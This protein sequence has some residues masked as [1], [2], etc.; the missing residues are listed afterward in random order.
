MSSYSNNSSNPDSFDSPPHQTPSSTPVA[1]E[2]FTIA[3]ELS[4]RNRFPGDKNK[5][6]FDAILEKLFRH[7][8]G[9][10]GGDFFKMILAFLDMRRVSDLYICFPIRSTKT[11]FPQI[12]TGETLKMMQNVAMITHRDRTASYDTPA[13]GHHFMNMLIVDGLIINVDASEKY[14]SEEILRRILDADLYSDCAACT[15][16]WS[17]PNYKNNWPDHTPIRKHLSGIFFKE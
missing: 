5:D 6:F 12:V 1:V 9:I 11:S 14:A 15:V 17:G 7:F 13:T 3:V 4:Q 8:L 16:F 2:K 10:N